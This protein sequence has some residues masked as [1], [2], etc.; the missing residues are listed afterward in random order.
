MLAADLKAEEDWT[1]VDVLREDFRDMV[2]QRDLLMEIP[3]SRRSYM[4]IRALGEG[5]IMERKWGEGGGL[6]AV[7]KRML[8]RAS[9]S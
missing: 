7:W 2:N 8:R 4:A 5:E 1:K 6:R 9:R 3:Q